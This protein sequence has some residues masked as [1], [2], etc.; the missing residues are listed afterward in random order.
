MKSKKHHD[1]LVARNKAMATHNESN[2]RLYHI[3][4]GIKA[5]CYSEHDTSYK[6]YGARGITV[7]DEW[8]SDYVSFRDWAMSHGYTDELSID[9][10]DVNGNY[11]P[12][13]CR[14]ATNTEQI[15]NR[16]DSIYLTY[17]GD[18]RHIAEWSEIT[19]IPL[20]TLYD[21]KSQKG[22]DDREVIEGKPDNR[23]IKLTV[24]GIVRTLSE[25]AA[26]TN[27]HRDKLYSRH[28]RGWSD[29]EV[30]YGR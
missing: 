3:W 15:R 14:W 6:D 23:S 30:V 22:W 24:D 26:I 5:R 1:M 8:Q 4:I 7:C 11:E 27:Q 21:R 2:T 19:G 16:R 20:N 12:S 13:N 9:R 29:K 18:T 28:R 25:W 17:K 10:I